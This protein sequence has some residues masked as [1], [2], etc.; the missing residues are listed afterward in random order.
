MPKVHIWDCAEHGAMLNDRSIVV[1][2]DVVPVDKINP[3][4]MEQYLESGKIK[5][6]VTKAAAPKEEPKAKETGKKK[7][8][9]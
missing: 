4:R 3:D 5:T 7:G 2:G 8:G 1:K 9:K 6:T